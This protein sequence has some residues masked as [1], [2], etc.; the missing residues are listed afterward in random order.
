MISKLSSFL[1]L[2]T[3]AFSSLGVVTGLHI[4]NVTDTQLEKRDYTN[5][6]YY[7]GEDAHFG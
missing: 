5:N 3:L 6:I 4:R 2:T 1:T 7:Y